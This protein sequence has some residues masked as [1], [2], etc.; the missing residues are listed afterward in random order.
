MKK[1]F[2]ISFQWI[3]AII[4]GVIIFSFLINFGYQQIF[5]GN[6]ATSLEL[7]NDLEL[8]LEALSVSDSLD[9][10]INT[11]VNFEFTCNDIRLDKY[12]QIT[13]KI[14]FSPLENKNK[15]N[16][17]LRTW[18]YPFKIADFYYISDAK[19]YLFNP[20]SLEIPQRFNIIINPSTFAKN[21]IFVFFSQPSQEQINEAL[22]YSSNIKIININDK[23]VTFIPSKKT[24]LY[25][26]DNFLYA[27]IF[28]KDYE[29]FTCLQSKAL[30][31]LKIIADLYKEK[32][33]FLQKDFTSCPYL[34]TSSLLEQLKTN[35]K[36]KDNIIAQNNLLKQND[37]PELY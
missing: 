16:I 19:F 14:I 12:S 18:N 15:L 10:E 22:K 17:W 7:I 20:P 6:K 35:L 28:A 25:I 37:C 24:A 30:D 34:L 5:L 3:F 29:T 26:D 11:K 8:Q 23:T 33:L 21:S 36:I 9:Q 1:G 13:E 31:K 4:A 32:A 2:A 27:A